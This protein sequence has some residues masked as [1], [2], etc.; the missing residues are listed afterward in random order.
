M[1]IK[2]LVPVEWNN[3][4]VLLSVQL[5]ES[6]KCSPK[7]ISD[8]FNRAKEHFK[9]GI[10]YFKLE[11]LV[12]RSFREYSEKIG[13]VIP[14]NT[15][16]LYL[17]TYQGCVRHCKSINTPE[18]WE[19]FNDLENNYFN[20][21]LV[22]APAPAVKTAEKKPDLARVYL[23]RL[24]DGT[25]L[26]VKIGHSKNIRSRVAK[27]KRETGLNVVDMY[28]TP[29]MLREN[30]RLVEWATQEKFSTRRIEGEFF[31]VDF[32]EAR[33]VIDYFV[34]LTLAEL[35]GVSANLI[36]DK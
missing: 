19:V 31:S 29:Y 36:A 33:K 16:R 22:A 30:A 28:F 12:L 24:S 5:A 13:L 35:P 14:L 21:S 18:A 27:I 7:N 25:V 1:E 23:L 20:P 2:N 3:Q 26:I 8:N 15:P 4:R 10:H 11:G 34:E 17:W 6:Y 32:D 9:E